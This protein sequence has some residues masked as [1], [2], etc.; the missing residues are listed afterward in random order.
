M[1]TF[2]TK[3]AIRDGEPV[4]TRNKKRQRASAKADDNL[5]RDEQGRK[6]T[7]RGIFRFPGRK[8]SHP[9]ILSMVI[10]NCD[11]IAVKAYRFSDVVVTEH[12]F[13]YH[14]GALDIFTTR[15]H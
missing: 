3:T 2:R 12:R 1:D 13:S 11:L 9:T 10:I 5:R 15:S 4:P 7:C 6:V 14:F 8:H